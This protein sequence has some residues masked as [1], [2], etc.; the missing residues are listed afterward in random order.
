[1]RSI[2]SSIFTTSSKYPVIKDVPSSIP[3]FTSE[4]SNHPTSPCINFCNKS[5]ETIWIV[6]SKGP[7][8]YILLT[9][10]LSPNSTIQYIV[11][12]TLYGGIIHLYYRNPYKWNSNW[13]YITGVKY[14]EIQD[15]YSQKIFVSLHHT[16]EPRRS[17]WIYNILDTSDNSIPIHVQSPSIDQSYPSMVFYTD[18]T[19]KPWVVRKYPTY[20]GFDR[21][22]T[23][24]RLDVVMI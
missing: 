12:D 6:L 16:N 10:E 20:S 1:M 15:E 23:S 8:T 21:K 24:N 14:K 11:D 2:L 4:F 13:P 3:E 7:G 5:V 18:P 19:S 22:K 17:F 9:E